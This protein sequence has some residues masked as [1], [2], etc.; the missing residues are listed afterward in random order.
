MA[1]TGIN[2]GISQ[3]L[4]ATTSPSTNTATTGSANSSED[5]LNISSQGQTLSEDTLDELPLD[6]IFNSQTDSAILSS[7]GGNSS[8][9]TS[10]L[11]ASS[12]STS[13]SNGGLYG[14]L[15][16]QTGALFNQLG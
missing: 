7:V 14:V 9:L 10:L 4:L 8:D 12:G 1:I 15:N 3:Q 11:S 5:L 6:L 16:A 13:S 2:S